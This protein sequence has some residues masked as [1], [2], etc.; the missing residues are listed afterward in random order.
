M[1]RGRVGQTSV[2]SLLLSD[3]QLALPQQLLL[4]LSHELH[5]HNIMYE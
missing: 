1:K 4:R 2:G 3:G 5:V